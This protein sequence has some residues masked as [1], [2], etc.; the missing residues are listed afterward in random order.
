[1]SGISEFKIAMK[2]GPLRQNRWEI[3][4]NFPSGVASID[5]SRNGALLARTA[6][7]P[8]STLGEILIPWR[9]KDFPWP[10]DRTVAEYPIT[11]IAVQ[12]MILHDGFMQWKD[13]LVSFEDN[14]QRGNF[15]DLVVDISMHLLNVRDERIKTYVLEDA[16]PREVSS[17]PG[18][19]SAK[20]AHSEFTVTFRYLTPRMVG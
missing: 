19:M 3:E 18:D 20:D 6:D 17:I 15:N 14:V 2:A 5:A 13:R 12:D 10:G 9:G 16:W 11:F 7:V 4:F 1:M 8:D